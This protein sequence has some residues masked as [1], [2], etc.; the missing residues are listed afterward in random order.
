MKPIGTCRNPRHSG[1]QFTVIT[2]SSRPARNNSITC[3]SSAPFHLSKRSLF[4]SSS[5]S[6]Q[7]PISLSMDGLDFISSMK[8]E[9]I[10]PYL[11]LLP[12]LALALILLQHL[13]SQTSPLICLSSITFS[14]FFCS[15]YKYDYIFPNLEPSKLL[16]LVLS[17]LKLLPIF[18]FV[19]S[20]NLIWADLH[21]HFTEIVLNSPVTKLPSLNCNIP[22]LSAAFDTSGLLFLQVLIPLGFKKTTFL[23]FRPFLY[24]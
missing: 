14:A 2:A 18:L 3:P 5:S 20:L 23:L 12:P 7:R 16:F 22:Y 19:S 13:T 21:P 24:Y 1:S 8:N 6:Y 17:A 4:S 11:L 10:T 9:A 15:V